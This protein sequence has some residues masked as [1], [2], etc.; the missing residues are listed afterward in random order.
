MVISSKPTYRYRSREDVLESLSSREAHRSPTAKISSWLCAAYPAEALAL[1]LC[2]KSR[3]LEGGEVA[4][5]L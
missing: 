4:A 2:E 5:L 3:L 1:L